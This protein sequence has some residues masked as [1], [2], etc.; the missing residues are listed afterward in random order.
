MRRWRANDDPMKAE[1]L[2][3]DLLKLAPEDLDAHQRLARALVWQGKAQE[4]YEVL[5]AAK[6][7]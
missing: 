4:A 5:K 1:A 2:L 7:D 3:R 6:T